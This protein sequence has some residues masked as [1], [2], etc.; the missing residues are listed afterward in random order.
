MLGGSSAMNYMVY[1]RGNKKNYDYWEELGNDGWNYENVLKY[2]KRWE[3]NRNPCIANYAKGFYHNQTGPNNVSLFEKDPNSRIFLKAAEEV[4]NPHI[5]DINANKTL[6]YLH[7]QGFIYDGVRQSAAKSYLIPAKN[8]RNLCIRKWSHVFEILFDEH[9]RAIGVKYNYNG[10]KNF[11][12]YARK[13]IILSAGVIGSAQLLLLSGIG[14]KHHLKKLGIE[15]IS[16]LAVGENLIDHVCVLVF[17]KF[18]G[19]PPSPNEALDDGYNYFIHRNGP[20]S[21][22]GID[23]LNGFVNTKHNSRWPDAQ[24]GHLL[25]TQNSD[26]LPGFLQLQNFTTGIQ[27]KLV[28]VNK[29]YYV[30]AAFVVLSQPKSTGTIK[31]KSTSYTE[32]PIIDANYFDHPEDEETMIRAVEQQIA[33]EKT[34]TFRKLKGQFISLPICNEFDFRSK[35]YLRC[36]N[37]HMSITFDH[38][39]GKQYDKIMQHKFYY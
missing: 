31:L 30:G 23:E 19:K 9:K 11:T 22:I 29:K 16:D 37:R 39:V 3:G 27:E 24:Y 32:H 25:F 36:Y 4:G 38:L 15:V 1:G 6:G 34:K 17:F 10:T 12:V 14:P 13:E 35:S 8:R 20:L 26:G 33:F 7:S 21:S 18:N 28:K 5:L 2:M